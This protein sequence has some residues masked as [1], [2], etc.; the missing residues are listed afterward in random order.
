MG[1]ERL[2]TE[3]WSWILVREGW[4]WILGR[5]GWNRIRMRNMEK[6]R[7]CRLI[8]GRKGLGREVG[9]NYF[10]FKVL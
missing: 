8:L 6:I 1:S 3:G 10:K 2:G 4:S 9:L 7:A 5:E